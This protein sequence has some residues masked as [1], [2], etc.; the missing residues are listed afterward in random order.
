MV[1]GSS[2]IMTQDILAFA[3]ASNG[4][5]QSP[6]S[7]RA[8]FDY[9]SHSQKEMRFYMTM[10]S[11]HSRIV[12]YEPYGS[13]TVWKE[14]HC[15]F[16]GWIYQIKLLCIVQRIKCPVSMSKNPEIMAVKMPSM[17]LACIVIQHVGILQ[18]YIHCVV[19][20]PSVNRIV[21]G[22]ILVGLGAGYVVGLVIL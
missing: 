22:C 4:C 2:S 18:N 6:D 1:K 7:I 21:I 13:P 20:F 19:E 17:D 5:W 3:A 8:L 12:S 15:V 9:D 14:R 16:H 11:P 10:E